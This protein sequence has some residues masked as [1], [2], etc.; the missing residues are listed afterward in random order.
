[1]KPLAPIRFRVFAFAV[2]LALATGTTTRGEA[3]EL[4][5]RAYSNSPVG[6][7][8]FVGG[9][10]Y[11]LGGLSVD[12]S[13][14]VQDAQI[15]IHSGVF[16]YARALDLWGKSGKVDMVLPLLALSGTG[17]VAGQA[18][19]RKISGFGDPRL[20]LSVNL[21]GAPALSMK[22]FAGYQPDL[23]IGASVQVS[24]P[25]GQ[26]D[27]NK[28]I[29]LGTNRWWVKADAGFSKAVRNFT[30]DVTTSAVLYSDNGHYFGGRTLEQSPIYAAQ[31]NLSYEFGGGVWGALG[32][33]YYHGGQTTLNGVVNSA[34]LGNSRAGGELVL[35]LSRYQ[36]VK[37]GLSRGVY[38]R[39]GTA[40]SLYAIA[41]QYRWGAGY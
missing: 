5:P 10:T 12:P 19:E 35:P 11:S 41:W 33:T 40:F 23:V 2:G 9:Y 38:T 32:T 29:N 31:A 17:T 15:R 3:Q 30:L 7:N 21:Y 20:R 22:E 13:V 1:M 18:A 27:Y 6:F 34:E 39:T 24:T 16:A 14:P 28:A 4:E 26:Y 25:L 37:L 36:S 8:F